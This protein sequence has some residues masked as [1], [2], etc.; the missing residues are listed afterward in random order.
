MPHEIGYSRL[1]DLF[2]LDVRPLATPAVVSASVNRRVNAE[3]KVLFPNGVAIDDTPVGHLE[4][5]LRHE[6]V[7]LEVI[8]ALFEHI[9][10][11]ELVSRFQSTPN[12][13]HIR[14]ACFLWEWLKGEELP[15]TLTPGAGYVD[16]FP[17]DVYVTAEEPVRVK[18]FL[19]R[20]N[21]LGTRD[22]C[23]TVRL[24]AVP[25][26]PSLEELFVEANRVLSA[27]SN[28]ELY[29]RAVRYLYLSETRGSYAIESETPSSDKT[30]RFMQLLSQAGEPVTAN[31]DW[32]VGLQNAIVRNAYSKEASYRAKLNWLE[33]ATGRISFFPPPPDEL[34]R[35]M[36]GWETFVNDQKRCRD[37]LVKATCISFG[38]VY[39]HPFM[40]GNGRLHR[41]LIHHALA[42]S[43]GLPNGAIIPV[44][45]VMLKKIP[46]YL[47]VLSAFSRPVTAL[48]SYQRGE[49]EP[50]ITHTPGSRPYRFFNADKEVAF[51]HDM[52]R[53]A[54]TDEIPH[55]LAWLHGYD[56]AFARLEQEF[57]LPQKD[58]SALIRM[59]HSNHGVLSQNRRKQYT[60]V[61][62][63]VLDRIEAV[64][65]ETFNPAK[66]GQA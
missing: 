54:V 50:S 1:I 14:R 27:V 8:E 29:D 13:E 59:A 23:P 52:I 33:D 37:T 20:D 15:T 11:A 39:L 24:S 34:R 22:F 25:R 46:Q 40:D 9:A 51:L 16:L 26:S 19:V 7:E 44:S 56:E 42:R 45:A 65:R 48:W 2:A 60:Y 30:E 3:N 10:P 21:A 6:G 58:L 31:E 28:R 41:F 66:P 36:A 47:E 12:G 62:E 32:L 17:N 61:P 53:Q 63:A 55:E 57:D 18:K 5:A 38:F 35:A 4:F 49:L 43:G 64:V